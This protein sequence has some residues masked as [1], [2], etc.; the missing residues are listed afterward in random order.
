MTK[1]MGHWALSSRI[2]TNDCLSHTVYAT[3]RSKKKEKP[4][5]NV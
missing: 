3:D 2:I 4:K 5:I 1:K